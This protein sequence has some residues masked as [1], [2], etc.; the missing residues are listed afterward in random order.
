MPLNVLQVYVRTD[1]SDK[2]FIFMKL[3]YSSKRYIYVTF[4]Q[5]NI[6]TVLFNEK[7]RVLTANSRS[8][9]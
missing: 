9:I 4:I 3:L 8:L 5:Y 2:E 6:P 1:I 7:R